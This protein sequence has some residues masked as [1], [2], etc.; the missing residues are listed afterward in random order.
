MLIT[1]VSHLS[2]MYTPDHNAYRKYASRIDRSIG[3]I[4]VSFVGGSFHPDTASADIAPPS[5]R[6]A[7]EGRG[8]KAFEPFYQTTNKT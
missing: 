6:A 7:N 3:C 4:G 2:I 5:T 8:S 1:L